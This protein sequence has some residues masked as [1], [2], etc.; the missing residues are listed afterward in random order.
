LHG[1]VQDG[2]E[3]CILSGLKPILLFAAVA[4]WGCGESA[5]P[6]KPEM[7]A[8]VSPGWALKSFADSGPPAGLPGGAA[9]QCWKALYEGAAGASAEVWVCGY[10]EGSSAFDAMQR[11]QTGPNT[12]KWQKDRYLEVVRWEG[13]SRGDVRALMSGLEKALGRP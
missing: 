11:A 13:G 4:L 6:G 5:G 7:P 2:K 10:R 3:Q 8:S 12:V 1:T 9:P